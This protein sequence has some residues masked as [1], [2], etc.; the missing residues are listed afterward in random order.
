MFFFSEQWV[1]E[2]GILTYAIE[3]NGLFLFEKKYAVTGIDFFSEFKGMH[4]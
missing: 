1:S 2:T 3:N 4:F